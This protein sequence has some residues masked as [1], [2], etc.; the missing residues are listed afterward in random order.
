MRRRHRD[1]VCL[2]GVSS[3]GRVVEAIAVPA[4]VVGWP[5]Y[6]IKVA[7]EI[8]VDVNVRDIGRHDMSGAL[9]AV[10]VPL[11]IVEQHVAHIGP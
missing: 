8:A 2:K 4:V 3:I 9:V 1:I 7:R 11:V 5:E 6:V 10:L